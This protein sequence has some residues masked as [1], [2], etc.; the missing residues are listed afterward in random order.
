MAKT[1]PEAIAALP[2]DERAKVEAR[3]TVLLKVRQACHP[4]DLPERLKKAVADA[5][6]HG[7]HDHLNKLLDDE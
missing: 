5:R 3:T 6:M 1:L 7:R 4:S 2:A